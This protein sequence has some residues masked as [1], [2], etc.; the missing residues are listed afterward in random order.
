MHAP[1]GVLT[2]GSRLDGLRV[3]QKNNG[4]A[5]RTT[6]GPR[7]AQLQLLGDRV[8]DNMSMIRTSLMLFGLLS[9]HMIVLIVG[10]V[11][12]HLRSERPVHCPCFFS[13]LT[14]TAH[15]PTERVH[16]ADCGKRI[17]V[18]ARGVCRQSAAALMSPDTL[19]PP[20]DREWVSVP[21]RHPRPD[22]RRTRCL[23][24]VRSLLS[25]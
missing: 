23:A 18:R 16:L 9:C 3:L 17:L 15:V 7:R 1:I 24:D 14:G 13:P 12:W 10:T 19:L 8:A 25:P 4:K 21:S 5:F 22:R 2:S 20:Q 11:P 6:R